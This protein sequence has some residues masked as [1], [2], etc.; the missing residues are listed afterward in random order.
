MSDS[1]KTRMTDIKAKIYK[2]NG[3]RCEEWLKREKW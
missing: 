2:K 3:R 1:G